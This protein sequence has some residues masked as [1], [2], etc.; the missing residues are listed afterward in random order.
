MT[1]FQGADSKVLDKLIDTEEI[2][3]IQVGDE[4]T[5]ERR[6]PLTAA[7][8]GEVI[9]YLESR[10]LRKNGQSAAE[11]PQGPSEAQTLRAVA[12][13]IGYLQQIGTL[14]QSAVANIDAVI[15]RVFNTTPTLNSSAIKL[16]DTNADN[17]AI[18]EPEPMNRS[19]QA[20][21][22]DLAGESS[23][24]DDIIEKPL[25]SD[26]H[27]ER[28]QTSQRPLSVSSGGGGEA[29]IKTTSKV[30]SAAK[31]ALLKARSQ[32]IS[33]R[34]MSQRAQESRNGPRAIP[35]TSASYSRPPDDASGSRRE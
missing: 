6:D 31:E 16:E 21:V 26:E 9:T 28:G 23:S 35:R 30:L 4:F 24:D 11:Q 8:E 12:S 2:V 14:N 3:R 33:L 5:R 1:E 32:P 13:S 29:E 25:K 7:E 17:P 15:S 27:G 10:R 34:T 20:Q 22:I 19:E 18:A